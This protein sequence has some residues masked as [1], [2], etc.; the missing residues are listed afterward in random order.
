VEDEQGAK[1]VTLVEEV[2]QMREAGETQKGRVGDLEEELRQMREDT[3][4]QGALEEEVG[5]MEEETRRTVDKAARQE[6]RD[7]VLDGRLGE[8]AAE[9]R[10]LKQWRCGGGGVEADEGSR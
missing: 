3:G 4:G 10:V 5:R 2:A 9:L 8:L 6:E 7:R 1:I